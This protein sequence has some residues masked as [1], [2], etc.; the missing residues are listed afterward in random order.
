M[1]GTEEMYRAVAAFDACGGIDVT[2]S[3]KPTDYNGM[4]IVKFGSGPRDC[5]SDLKS[6]RALAG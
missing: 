5:A 2:A 4:K 6:I 3:H 1:A